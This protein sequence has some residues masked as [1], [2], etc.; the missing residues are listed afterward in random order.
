MRVNDAALADARIHIGHA[1]KY[2]DAAVREALGPLNLV[3]VLGGVVVDR[4]PEE[5]AQIAE[6]GAE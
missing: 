2:A 6:F 5:A 1:D 4:G 3:K